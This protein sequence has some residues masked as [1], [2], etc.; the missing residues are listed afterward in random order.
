VRSASHTPLHCPSNE[1]RN[2]RNLTR[3]TTTSTSHCP[4][5]RLLTIGAGAF[6][7]NG[8]LVP[9]SEP[10]TTVG[11]AAAILA[12]RSNN[13]GFYRSGYYGQGCNRG[14]SVDQ[15]TLF[16]TGI[17]KSRKRNNCKSS[18]NKTLHNY[19]HGVTNSTEPFH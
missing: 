8:S 3:S 16:L 5:V 12:I 11:T 9:W 4:L 7:S 14:G 18:K 17:N 15:N 2:L 6:N 13:N 1:R 19:L 10:T